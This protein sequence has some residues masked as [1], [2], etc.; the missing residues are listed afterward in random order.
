MNQKITTLEALVGTLPSDAG[1]TTVV[2]YVKAYCDAAIAA[3]KIGDYAKDTDLT[4]AIGRI[5]TAEGKLDTLTGTDAVE[6]SVAKA[7]KDAKSYVD[8]LN[9]AMDGRMD[10]VEGQLAWI[11]LV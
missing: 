1:A 11:E 3:L 9:T 6:G 10:V 5:T 7:L 8:G 4:A 2:G